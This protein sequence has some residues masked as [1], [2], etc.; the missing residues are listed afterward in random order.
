LT[1]TLASASVDLT[2]PLACLAAGAGLNIDGAA[3][4]LLSTDDAADG[5]LGIQAMLIAGGPDLRAKLEKAQGHKRYDVRR[6]ALREL[7]GDA[8]VLERT[9]LIATA[10]DHSADVRLAFAALMEKHRWPE[11]VDALVKL[12]GD[13]RN[14]ASQLGVGSWS[15]FSVAR[16]AARAL[17]AYEVLPNGAIDA[18]IEAA[19]AEGPDPFVACAALSALANRDDPRVMPVM[20]WA[21]ASAGLD[22]SRSHRPRAQAAAWALCDRA[23]SGRSDMLTPDVARFAERDVAAVAGPLLVA[24]GVHPCEMRDGLLKR[25]RASGQHGREGLVVTAA[26][27]ANGAAGMSLDVREQTLCRLAG[28]EELDSLSPADRAAVEAWSRG[29]NL[30]GG[31]ERFIAWIAELVFKLP[32]NGDLGDIRAFA[33]P[34]RI[35]VLTMRSMTPHREE[36]GGGVDDGA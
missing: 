14:F 10:N 3:A 21:L 30:G 1:T 26:V 8:T 25:L 20:Q 2:G 17:G 34:E 29:L 33:L 6:R 7:A 32:L 19:R 23:T 15:K 36:D 5:E 9:R 28:G 31:F 27:A 12:L 24:I 35:G 4:R 22:R 18:I 13:T 16:T 11:A